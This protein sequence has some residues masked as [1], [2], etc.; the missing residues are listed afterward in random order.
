MPQTGFENKQTASLQKLPVDIQAFELMRGENYLYVDKTRYIYQMLTQARYY[1][2]SRPRRFGKSLLVSTLKCLFQG[3]KELFEGLWIVEHGD[4]E[5]K[6]H[7]VILLDFNGMAGSSPEELKTSIGLRLHEIAEDAGLA[8][9]TPFIELQFRELILTFAKQTQM[10]VVVLIDEYDKRIIQHL[11]K[12]Q[13]GLEIAKGNR[14]VLKSFF[15]ILKD[16][17]VAPILRFVFLTG[18]SRFSKVSIFSE[19]NNL[20]DLSMSARYAEMLG[21]TQ[22][23]L[24]TYFSQ[25]LCQLA[26]NVGCSLAKL[27]ERLARQYNGYRFSK[28]DVRVYNPYSILKACAEMDVQDYWF[29]TATPSFL[30]NYLM[31][32]QYHLPQLEAL[33]VSQTIFGSFDLERLFPE[34]LLF[35]TGYLTIRDVQKKVYTLDYPNQ[36]VKTA[37]SESLFLA[38]TEGAPRTISSH[39]L[40]LAG[41]L[42]TEDFDAFFET[43]RAIFAS[44]PYTI[45]AK[46]DEAYFHTIFY[47]MLTASGTEADCEPITSQGRIDLVVEFSEKVFII[48]FKCNQSADAAIRQIR[49]KNYADKYRRRDKNIILIGINFSKE[50]RNIEEWKVVQD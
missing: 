14:D 11:G 27:K 32:E 26:E 40:Y 17:S 18:V 48:E 23:E 10:P 37:F 45:N 5:W 25:Y 50:Q 19:L 39:V 34:A 44:I 43:M 33:Q 16:A 7:P 47:L 30:V 9:E 4:W 46:R 24:E 35:Q 41:Y 8:L 42:E 2:L 28:K 38:L 22:A 49:E 1:F 12:G 13:P 29:E 15:G 6:A 20:N 3:R 31:Q 21:Y 36:E